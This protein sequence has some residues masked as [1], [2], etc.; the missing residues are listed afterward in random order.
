MYNGMWLVATKAAQL[1]GS[2]SNISLI[3]LCE[4]AI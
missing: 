3:H 4:Q 1:V 2:K